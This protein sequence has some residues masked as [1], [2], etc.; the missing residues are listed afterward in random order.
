MKQIGVDRYGNDSRIGGGCG[1]CTGGSVS[2]RP[3]EG[4]EHRWDA[5]TKGIA[6]VCLFFFLSFFPLAHL[7]PPTLAISPNTHPNTHFPPPPP[8]ILTPP[9][10]TLV[11]LLPFFFSASTPPYPFFFS[12]LGLDH[13]VGTKITRVFR[14]KTKSNNQRGRMMLDLGARCLHF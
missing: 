10:H 5:G 14:K 6:E 7:N 4:S 13:P 12:L 11:F 9:T 3:P 2:S 8:F 1:V